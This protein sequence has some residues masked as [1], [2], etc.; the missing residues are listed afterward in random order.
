MILSKNNLI[1]IMI[2]SLS[3]APAIFSG[4]G[5]RNLLLIVVMGLAPISLLKIFKIEKIDLLLIS[6]I[7][8]MLIGPYFI[9]SS[10]YRISTVLYS[11][12]FGLLFITYKQ[13]LINSDFSIYNYLSLIK[14]IIFSYF[15]VLLIQQFCV[16]TGLP[17]F[18]I[19]NYDSSTP[20]KLNSLAAEPSHTGRI[21][22]LLMFTYIITKELIQ[23]RKYSLSTDL[24]ND[25]YLF[26]AFLWVVFTSGSAT[27]YLFFILILL[28]FLSFR[29]AIYL[30]V[31]II[32]AIVIIN[33]FGITS[34][35][36]PFDFMMAVLTL[37][38]YT[39]MD[40]DHSASMR[41]A[42][43]IVVFDNINIT[44]INGFFGH[45]IDSTSN[46]ISQ[47]IHGI[48]ENA[49]GGGMFQIWYEYGFIVFIL[50]VLYSF[51]SI[52]DKNN[53]I[54]ILFWVLLVFIAG[55]NS[56][57]V[58]LC[59]VLLYTNNYFRKREKENI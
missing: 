32:L 30:S 42:P 26:F 5:N 12:L 36:R 38:L 1:I 17:I 45:G 22:P 8:I 35:Q 28:K 37:D 40:V 52:Y 16:I 44:N 33:T 56:Q 14:F 58:W 48:Q 51:I 54:N 34:Y 46:I 50:F 41:I 19:S 29:N 11:V 57:M 31:I 18:N 23:K 25:K 47:Y 9:D 43:S 59:I 6:M 20:W 7:L 24:Y 13:L 10:V 49:T 3:M 15:I 4:E 2:L 53:K 39:M 27:A 21:V 55:I